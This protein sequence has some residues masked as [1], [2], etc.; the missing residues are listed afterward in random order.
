VFFPRAYDDMVTLVQPGGRHY[1]LPP[2]AAL[3]W[4]LSH[5]RSARTV[6]EDALDLSRQA[7]PFARLTEERCQ[8]IMTE[9]REAGLL[10]DSDGQWG[11]M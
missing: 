6:T 8:H 7:P 3:V 5:G 9:L 1:R 10:T 4:G 11:A 2:D